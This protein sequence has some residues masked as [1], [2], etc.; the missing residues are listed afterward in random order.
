V[1]DQ[2]DL[3]EFIGG[4]IVEAE[5]L[6]ST[7]NTLLLEIDAANLTRTSKPRAVRDLFRC[8][9]TLKGLAGMVGIEPIV[10]LAHALETLVRTADRSGGTLRHGAVEVALQAVRAIGDRVRAVA[11]R[12]APQPAPTAIL[13]A[14]A[15]TDSGSDDAPAPS[16]IST[17]WDARLTAS[18]R[19]QVSNAFR[20]NQRVYMLTFVPTEAS[21]ARG[22][23]IGTVRATLA[24]RGEVVK[25]V[26]RTLPPVGGRPR[27]GF[28]VLLISGA[29]RAA[30]AEAAAV[31]EDEV[32]DVTPPKQVSLPVEIDDM[33]PLGRS[34]VRVELVRLDALQEQLAALIVSRF[35]LEREIAEQA[36]RGVDV[37]RLREVSDLQG[38][39]LRDLRRGILRVRMVRVSEILEPLTL[40]IRSLARPGVKEVKLELD[41]RDTEVDKAVADRLLP[42]IIHLVRNAIDHAIEPVEERLALGK[43]RAGTLRVSCVEVGGSQLELSIGDD[44]RGIDRVAIAARAQRSVSD[45]AELLEV[46][47]TPGFSMRDTTSQTSG[48]G[49]GMD[50]VRRVAVG[51]LGGQLSLVTELGRGTTFRLRVPLT[52]AIIEVFSFACGP[53]SF[54]VPVTAIEEI[55]EV[56]PAGN[57]RPPDPRGH[58]AAVTM[59]ERK[60]R[61][62]SLVSLGTLLAIDDGAGARKALL[63]RRDGD[64][65][66]FAVDR[67]LGRHEVVVRPLV[68]PLATAP[69]I[70]GATDLGDGRPTLVLDLFELGEHLERRVS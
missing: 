65:L 1:T 6:V 36:G 50:I 10:E 48:R 7:A 11:D 43:P 39:Q 37:R 67:M 46:L 22:V 64:P 32:L 16:S 18:E 45:D 24:E 55:F 29:T 28:D 19:Q 9:H 40:L 56:E 17:V 54:V 53:Q 66:A 52:I 20:A 58:N 23:S 49:L 59:C 8:L 35:R 42:A 4:F 44:G 68:D 5:E 12:K 3:Q 21:A 41:A 69:G 70:S 13:E 34:V 60:G 57:A 51:E 61:A 33:T 38:R 25:V 62:V 63:V 30:I 2:V 31:S 47:T 27:V 15:T 14:L 26:P